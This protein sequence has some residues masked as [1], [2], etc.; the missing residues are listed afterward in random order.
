[1]CHIPVAEYRDRF[2][3][4]QALVR[5]RGLDAFIVS[6]FDSIYY[7]T[8]AGFEPLER[9]F[10]LVIGPD[11]P[12]TLLV[13]RLDREHMRKAHNVPAD[14]IRDYGEYPAPVGNGWPDRLH[15]VIGRA[16]QIGVEP[17]LRLEIANELRDYTV[18][19]EPL[20]EQLRLIKS[21]AEIEM[22]R[23]T[24]RYADFG[25]ERLLAKSYFGATIAEGFAESR[26]VNARI[27][28]EVD[29]WDP[30]TTKV[31]M[32]TWA[33]P[34][35]AMPHSVPN[36]NDR[37]HDGP[38]V[39][40]AFDRVNGYAAES[41]RTFFTVPPSAEARRAFAAMLEARRIASDSLRPGV[42]CDEIDGRVHEFLR[43]EGYSGPNHR[44]HRTGHGIGL[45]NHEGPWIAEGSADRLAE[46]MVVSVEPGVYLP[47]LG[48][49][50]H[51]DTV[52]IT[53]DGCEPLTQVPTDLASLTVR[54]WRPVA[55][56][57]GGLVRRK[58][59]LRRQWVNTL[60]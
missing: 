58:L 10:F 3:S 56:F 30:L 29:D 6:A 45:S 55:R 7:L 18:R 48:G 4:L 54:S 37:L 2:A 60:R 9:P 15:E 12:P 26:T 35:S 23:R 11:D 31:L 40:L 50:R 47:G 17:T 1:M 39:A 5:E 22:I 24:A 21:P 52:R 57:T 25:V 51:S 13:P 59:R 44:L 43:R 38:H 34:R 46:N 27:I 20:V 53:H 8:G 28:R 16:Q 42:A 33:A 14:R 49:F 41:E 19:V 32:A 36:L